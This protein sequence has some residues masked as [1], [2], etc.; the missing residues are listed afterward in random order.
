MIKNKFGRGFFYGLRFQKGITPVM[1]ETI[2]F[3]DQKMLIVILIAFLVGGR[4]YIIWKK[5]FRSL[6]FIDRKSIEICWTFLP[7]FILVTLAIPSLELLY[8]LDCPKDIEGI[9]TIRATGMQWY[10]KYDIRLDGNSTNYNFDSYMIPEKEENPGFR[11][12]EVDNPIFVPRGEVVKLVV[13]GGD[14]IH[15]F[16][17]PS[18]GIK[19]DG[20]PGRGNEGGFIALK[21]GS[22]YGQCSEICGAN[23]RFM[24]INLEV[25]PLRKFVKAFN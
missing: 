6:E 2:K 24:P 20:V 3:H 8:Y 25:I 12:L 18:L 16:A 14:V 23:H 15:S 13:R 19:M 11:L 1:S 17:I 21:Y 22:Y 4:I 10:W 5:R 7:I 9:A